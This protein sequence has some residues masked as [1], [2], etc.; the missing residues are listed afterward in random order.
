MKAKRVIELVEFQRGADPA[1][2]LDIGIGEATWESLKERDVL[3]PKIRI[4]TSSSGRILD[5]KYAAFYI[6]RTN[7]YYEIVEIEEPRFPNLRGSNWM[8]KLRKV[9]DKGGTIKK[10]YGS[11]V[12]LM[13]RLDIIPRAEAYRMT[14]VRESLD[15]HKGGNPLDTLEVGRIEER[16]DAAYRSFMDWLTTYPFK[17]AD[18]IEETYDQPYGFIGDDEKEALIFN[19]LTVDEVSKK[20]PEEMERYLRIIEKV[21]CLTFWAAEIAKL[22]YEE[23]KSMS[24]EDKEELEQKIEDDFGTYN[25]LEYLVKYFINK[26]PGKVKIKDPYESK[27]RKR[28]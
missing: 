9:S 18:V 20:T 6:F 22:E 25:F 23:Y 2:S 8:L 11:L 16:K 4:N 10:I 12:K 1:K 21:F 28:S 3:K 24:E 19:G 7:E 15:F 14:S 5:T 13:N 27:K 26:W 17:E